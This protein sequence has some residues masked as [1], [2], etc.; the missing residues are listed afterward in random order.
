MVGA[1]RSEIVR[2]IFGADPIYSGEI[3]INGE[4]V[5][6]R[7]PKHAIKSKMALVSE[8]RHRQSLNLD[9]SRW[10]EYY[11]G[12]CRGKEKKYIQSQ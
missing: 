3:R 7:K 8:D 9:M 11:N 10:G 2:G 12:V 6:I 5:N 1:G 4:K